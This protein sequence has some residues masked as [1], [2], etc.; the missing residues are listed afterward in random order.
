MRN[1]RYLMEC[2]LGHIVFSL[3]ALQDLVL[4]GVGDACQCQRVSVLLLLLVYLH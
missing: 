1:G 2:D 4:D 3:V